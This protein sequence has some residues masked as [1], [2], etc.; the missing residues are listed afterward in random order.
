MRAAL[1]VLRS[2]G[3]TDL[4]DDFFVAELKTAFRRLARS[5]HPDMRPSA[6]EHEKRCLVAQ[7]REIREAYQVLAMSC[8]S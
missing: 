1:E 5:A 6:G 4:R 2:A 8:P 7:F 3:A